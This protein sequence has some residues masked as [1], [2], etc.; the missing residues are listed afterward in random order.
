MIEDGKVN[1]AE[2]TTRLPMPVLVLN[3]DHGYYRTS[4]LAGAW[5]VAERIEKFVQTRLRTD[6]LR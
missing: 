1:R 6:R 4:L 3:G 5:Q 2:F